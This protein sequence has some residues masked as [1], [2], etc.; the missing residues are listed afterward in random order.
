[1]KLQIFIVTAGNDV[2]FETL[3][4]LK[5]IKIPHETCVWYHPLDERFKIEADF[6]TRLTSYTDD[7]IMA[8]KNQGC[9]PAFGY[10]LVYKKYD[11]FLHLD[12]DLVVLDGAVEKMLKLHDFYRRLGFVGEG[13]ESDKM[14]VTY[15]INNIKNL[16]D[17]GG[18]FTRECINEIGSRGAMFPKYGFDF[19][20][21]QIRAMTRGWKVINHKGFFK[22]GGSHKHGHETRAKMTDLPEIHGQSF[23]TFRI[24]EAM[25]FSNYNWW[26]DKI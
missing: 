5:A 14:A 7:V 23:A 25:N 22:H 26:A 1:M 10:G 12:D 3:E 21:L 13:I 18:I 11:Y 4:S 17:W 15:E 9:P 20:E 6:F 19:T 16:P 8:T 24:L 2:V